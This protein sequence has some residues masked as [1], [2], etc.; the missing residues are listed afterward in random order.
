LSRTW[1]SIDALARSEGLEAHAR[2]VSIR[3]DPDE[4]PAKDE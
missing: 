4:F 3:Q 1:K 2:S